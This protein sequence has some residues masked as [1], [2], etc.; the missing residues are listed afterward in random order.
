M[1]T[2]RFAKGLKMGITE[3][4]WVDSSGLDFTVDNTVN[5]VIITGAA[6]PGINYGTFQSGNA[7]GKFFVEQDPFLI[8]SMGFRL[9]YCFPMSTSVGR[10]GLFW[11]EPT[12]PQT[13]SI[14]ELPSWNVLPQNDR[15]FPFNQYIKWDSGLIPG[16]NVT[17]A[18]SQFEFK[19]SM[20]GVPASLNGLTLRVYPYM[21]ITHNFGLAVA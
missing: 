15:E 17:V 8:I 9:P 18:I 12:T 11:R 13:N 1:D 10:L 21:L 4:L 6:G 5:E 16:K 7:V 3:N 20:I 14:L 2:Y 19:I